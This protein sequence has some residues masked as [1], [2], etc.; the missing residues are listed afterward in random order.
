MCWSSYYCNRFFL[1]FCLFSML[2]VCCVMSLREDSSLVLCI[3]T[4]FVSFKNRNEQKDNPIV[5][6]IRPRRQRRTNDLNE[7]KKNKQKK[8]HNFSKLFLFCCNNYVCDIDLVVEVSRNGQNILRNWWCWWCW[9]WC[10]ATQKQQNEPKTIDDRP[11][12]PAKTVP[13]RYKC[14]VLN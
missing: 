11:I 9:W 8:A 10:D 14:L 6:N 4:P 5:H 3:L 2:C 7:Q 12:Q 13:G 1:S